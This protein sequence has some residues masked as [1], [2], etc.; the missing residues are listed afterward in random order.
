MNEWNTVIMLQS[1]QKDYHLEALAAFQAYKQTYTE[2]IMPL[3]AEQ[4]EVEAAMLE[5]EPTAAL[6]PEVMHAVSTS[7]ILNGSSLG[8]HVDDMI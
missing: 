4:N 5:I 7:Q 6:D 2:D 1:R 8:H 3:L